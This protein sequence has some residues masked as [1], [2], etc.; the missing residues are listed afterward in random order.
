MID[1]IRGEEIARRTLDMDAMFRQRHRVFKERLGWRVVS[2]D[3][4]EKDDYDDLNPIYLL[5]FDDCGALIGS[6]RILPSTG[7]YMLKD[8]FPQLLDGTPP[9]V[10]PQI[11]EGSRLAVDIP[12]FPDE[13]GAPSRHRVL[14]AHRAIAEIFCAV[15]E[16]CL[17]YDVRAF[18]TVYD[19]R[20]ARIYARLGCVP[21]WQSR[22]HLIGDTVTF[23]SRFDINPQVLKNIQHVSGVGGSVI[24]S[25]PWKERKNAA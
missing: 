22:R 21:R 5:A 23:A 12:N 10:D 13:D 14:M 11:W 4:R 19:L 6:A 2:R 24:R 1:V 8:T 18:M 20:V 7:R 3:G 17:A 9:P 25:A 16:T 15:V